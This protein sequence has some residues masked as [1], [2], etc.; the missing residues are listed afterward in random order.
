MLQ[1]WLHRC[2]QQRQ[3]H[4]C[5]AVT[6]TGIH[7]GSFCNAHRSRC[8]GAP[9]ATRRSVVRRHSGQITALHH[10]PE[11]ADATNALGR[12]RT[13]RLVVGGVRRSCGY[14][15]RCFW[16]PVPARD[17]HGRARA[18]YC[19]RQPRWRHRGGRRGWSFPEA[20]AHID[21]AIA[22]AIQL[23]KRCQHWEQYPQSR[24][25]HESYRLQRCAGCGA[26]CTTFSS[27]AAGHAPNGA[28]DGPP[29]CTWRRV[30][31]QRR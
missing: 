5:A 25:K 30:P 3:L 23:R 20:C 14:S 18:S 17:A 31:L 26:P 16:V 4:C 10:Q 28:A 7:A 24:G 19:W 11:L 29:R 13:R 27:K 8:S 22:V 12:C 21:N 9:V 1:Q 15:L 2:F 6:G